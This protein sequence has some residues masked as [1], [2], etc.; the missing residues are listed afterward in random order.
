MKK[1]AQAALEFLST[2]GWAILTV[3]VVILALAT[4][5]VLT[6]EK[7][8]GSQCILSPGLACVDFKVETERIVLVLQNGLGEPMTI[9]Q[10]D[11]FKNNGK[12]CSVAN[13]VILQDQNRAI[14]TIIGCSNGNEKEKFIG[15]INVTYSKGFI[16]HSN[17]GSIID[18]VTSTNAITSSVACQNADGAGLCPGLDVVYGNSYQAACCSEWSLCCS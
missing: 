13:N 1:K 15:S 5:G 12:G 7:F 10:V 3:L 2:Y 14:I 17:K 16:V 9:Y 8:T 4:F 18:K 6:P 11:A